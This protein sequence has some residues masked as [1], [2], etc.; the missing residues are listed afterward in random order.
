MIGIL[1][2]FRDTLEELGGDLGVTDR[3]SGEA[4]VEMKPG[5]GGE[6]AGL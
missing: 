2:R 1:D 3:V 6:L 5:D 4:V